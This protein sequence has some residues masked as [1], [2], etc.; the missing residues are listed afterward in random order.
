MNIIIAKN[1]IGRAKAL[2]VLGLRIVFGVLCK[3][4]A[5]HSAQRETDR[6]RDR[7]TDKE[8]ERE[9]EGESHLSGHVASQRSTR[10]R[11]P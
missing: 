10:G 8:R 11:P 6:D 4:T 7:D 5:R 1:I 2:V 9:R 3:A